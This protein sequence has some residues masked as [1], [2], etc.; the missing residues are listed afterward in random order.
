MPKPIGLPTQETFWAITESGLDQYN[1]AR[2]SALEGLKAG[3]Y[4][5]Y[6]DGEDDDAQPSR[7]LR[8][9]GSI[10]V[11]SIKGPLVNSDSWINELFGLVSY[12]AIR[13]ALIEAA[14]HPRIDRI[15]L[16][17]DSP[18]GSVNGVTDTA[19][20]ISTIDQRVKPVF[21]FTDGTMASGAYWL[22]SSAREIFASQISNIG[23]I[24]VIVNHMER[25]KQL[26]MNGIKATVIRAG[27]YKQ[28]GNPNEP[29]TDEGLQELQSMVDAIYKIFVTHVSSERGKSYAY[30]DQHMAQGRVFLGE[31]ALEVGLVDHISNF[32]ATLAAISAK[33]I[34][35]NSISFEN[36]GIG[37]NMSKNNNKT[38]LAE[39]ISTALIAAGHLPVASGVI[40]P[41]AET[42]TEV[43]A[44]AVEPQAKAEDTPAAAAKVDD[45]PAAEPKVDDSAVKTAMTVDL[46][47]A[48]MRERED[49]LL[50]VKFENR[51]LKQKLDGVGGAMDGLKAIAVKSLNAMQVAL[52]KPIVD[53]TE[54]SANDV[55]AS[56]QALT[57]EFAK[58]FPVGGV[59]AVDP[60]TKET[61]HKAES[62]DSLQ[63]ARLA[64]T[65]L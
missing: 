28:V 51:E 65:K 5:E 2:A 31:T 19:E 36:N 10:G 9:V 29:L 15:V 32:D 49:E 7:L 13:Q 17:I 41:D 3:A 38:P 23:S 53:Y 44:P 40:Q 47:K 33:N 62:V 25:S 64:A 4:D 34:D 39:A 52:N 42:T 21:A 50:E 57:A 22:G 63:A 43:Q 18:G 16:D 45:E 8:Q 11:I 61:P 27:K 6:D 35:R 1:D 20:L 55:L 24:G 46:L 37:A 48:Q 60:G 56:H 30:A 54:V 59:A 26:E 14:T 12:G 58:S